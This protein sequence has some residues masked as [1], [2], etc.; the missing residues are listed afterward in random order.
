MRRVLPFLLLLPALIAMT[1]AV[2]G[3]EKTIGKGKPG[4]KATPDDY[5]RLAALRTY[6]GHVSVGPKSVSF[7]IDD[8]A[9]MAE[10]K[11]ATAMPNIAA[12]KAAVARVDQKYAASKWAL[13][14]EFELEFADKIAL[15]R[16]NQPFEYDA[17][18]NPKVS[19]VAAGAGGLPGYPA[20]IEDFSSESVSTVTFGAMKNGKPT[21]TMIYVD[22][23]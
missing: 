19:N 12:Q 8:S 1:A 6:T 21:A 17:K 14:K 10:L 16:K 22:N 9:Y 18:G 15:R 20:K 23:K 13:G 5:K 2:T 3:Q 7:K 11:I 4:V